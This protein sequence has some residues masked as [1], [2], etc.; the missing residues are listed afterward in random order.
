M[1]HGLT[2]A[3]ATDRGAIRFWFCNLLEILRFSRADEIA[4]TKIAVRCVCR[5]AVV[6]QPTDVGSSNRNR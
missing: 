3:S 6:Y 5:V 2:V 4:V 1:G